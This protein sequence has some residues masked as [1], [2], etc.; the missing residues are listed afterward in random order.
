MKKEPDYFAI[1]R[2]WDK[3]LACADCMHC[4]IERDSRP[5]WGSTVYE[6]YRACDILDE[7]AE[8]ECP[9]VIAE[10]EEDL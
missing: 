1:S 7:L 4:H 2:V 6:T 10:T 3:G 9:G 5:Y 8:G